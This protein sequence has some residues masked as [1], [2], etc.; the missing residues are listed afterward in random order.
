MH[1]SKKWQRAFTFCYIFVFLLQMTLSGAISTI[2][3]ALA[4]EIET[5]TEIENLSSPPPVFEPTDLW[6]KSSLEFMPACTVSCEELVSEV[7]NHGDEPMAGS[8]TYEL[9]Y[10]ES[11]PAKNGTLLT[12]GEVPALSVGACHD[13]TF[14]PTALGNYQFRVSQRPGHPGQAELWSNDCGVANI[15]SCFKPI[16]GDGQL[17]ATEGC[18]DG[19]TIDNDGCSAL[20]ELEPACGDGIINQP[21]EQCDDG[22]TVDTDLCSNSCLTPV[23]GDGVQNGTEQCDDGNTAADDGCSPECLIEQNLDS[24]PLQSTQSSCFSSLGDFQLN[25]LPTPYCGDGILNGSEQCDDGNTLSGDG[26]YN[27]RKTT[28]EFA[29]AR[30]ELVANGTGLTAGQPQSFSLNLANNPIFGELLW[31]ARRSTDDTITLNS[32][33]RTGYLA[34]PSLDYDNNN[35]VFV[36]DIT[37]LLS[38]GSNNLSVGGLTIS[39]ING[40][41][42]GAAALVVV[43]GSMEKIIKIINVNE[44]VYS[45]RESG[46]RTYSSVYTF[47]VDP[48]PAPRTVTLTLVV[49]DTEGG[50]DTDKIWYT[51]GSGSVPSKIAGTGTLLANNELVGNKGAQIDIFT[52]NITL[53]ANHN[54]LAVQLESPLADHE[55]DSMI[56]ASL[57]LEVG[58]HTTTCGDGV[59]NQSFEQCD[60]GNQINT[61]GCTNSCLTP[62]CGDG[63]IWTG[64]E[65]CDDNGQNGAV[66]TPPY[67]GECSYCSEI[68]QPVRLVG[69][70]CGDGIKNGP[71]Q[72]DGTDG[73]IFGQSCTPNCTLVLEPY[74]G[75]GIINQPSEECDDG[76]TI[77]NDQCRNNCTLTECEFA[78]DVMLVM[79][80]SGSMAYDSPT[81]LSLAQT[82]ANN[83]LS[84]LN[85][86]DQSGLVSFA[87]TA[88]LDENLSANHAATQ[89]AV[90]GLSPLGATNIGDAI[91]L[92]NNELVSV[93]H[94]PS[95]VSIEILITDGMA[96]RP[97][98]PGYGEYQPDVDY[99]LAKAAEAAAAGI[100]IFTVGLGSDINATML[101]SI[102]DSTGGKYYSS[103]TAQ[104][105]EDIFSEIAFDVCQYG[106]I[107]G[108][109]YNDLNHNGQI[110]FGEPAIPGW[111]IILENDKTFTQYTD[112]TGCYKFTGVPLDSYTLREGGKPG[113]IFSQTYPVPH[114][115]Y[116]SLTAPEDL[117]GYNFANYLP[118]CG[119]NIID[120]GYPGYP[121]EQCDLGAQNGLPG[122]ACNQDCTSY[123]PFCGD[124]IVNQLAEQCD[125]GNTINNDSCTNAC[126]NPVC[127]DGIVNNQ[128]ECDDGNQDNTDSCLNTC[129]TPT[130]GDGFIWAGNELCDDNGN[131]GQVCTPPY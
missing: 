53:P 24:L 74:C 30:Q 69:P 1:L 56:L 80:R 110:D 31:T 85:S 90:N 103:P 95:A 19:N 124:G 82:A 125:D 105:L 49:G 8:T 100:K 68:C 5:K 29:C 121:D 128:E 83:F 54:F 112:Q 77:D 40:R 78:L 119:N 64:H 102:A 52:K 97:S 26:C 106:T 73:L 20:C 122:S 123:I 129:T 32:V 117:T 3:F 21:S 57:A 47:A 43:P 98:G 89:T 7:C 94:N 127:G 60:D 39:G 116:V 36:R 44:F 108:C 63:F 115:Y 22:N 130:C 71:E 11:G 79:D 58:C 27:C 120:S 33:D 4:E 50:L 92:A 25:C 126:L 37:S 34:G 76:N 38:A 72:C 17:D 81:R 131:N 107:A 46:I 18:D 65:T 59:V 111:E 10:S 62:V 61:D 12:T 9:W 104:E 87:N 66:C 55:A 45:Q 6:D 101:Q 28:F 114:D 75:D 15:A 109:K 14:V 91:K 99:A 35:V 2:P 16:C 96:N 67:G 86:T 70:Y 42:D 41:I 84:Y 113:V 23:C 93:R 118:Y 51:T 48:L 13:L 88:T